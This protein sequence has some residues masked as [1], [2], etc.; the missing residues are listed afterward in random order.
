MYL[1]KLYL[2]WKGA[3]ARPPKYATVLVQLKCNT[4]PDTVICRNYHYCPVST[5][6]RQNPVSGFFTKYLCNYDEDLINLDVNRYSTEI[7]LN[8]CN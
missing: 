4:E 1:K 8:S 6:P 5:F 3:S 7:S 2:M